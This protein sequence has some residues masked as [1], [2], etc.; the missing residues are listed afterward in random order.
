MPGLV[1]RFKTF[2]DRFPSG[3]WLMMG[4]DTFLTAGNSMVFPFVALYLHNERGLPMSLVGTI[5]LARGLFTGAANVIGGM[6]SD[7][8]GRKRLLLAVLGFN[9]VTYVILAFL[10][11]F[12][13][14][15]WIIALVYIVAQGGIVN[16]T[17]SAIVA[18]LSPAG[19]L[20]EAYAV[21]RIGGNVG[22]ALGPAIGGFLIAIISYGWLLA[23]SAGM[24]VIITVLII[25]FLRE[26]FSG[27]KTGVSLRSTLAV[28][29]DRPFVVFAL[30]S[31][32]L[33]LSIG[34]LGSTLSVFTVERLGFTTAQYGLLLTANGLM[35]VLLQYPVTHLVNKLPKARGLALGSLFY[36]LGWSSFGWVNG[37]GLGILAIMV[38]TLGEVTLVPIS[39]AVVAEAAPEDRRGRYMG[40]FA[41][42]QTLGYSLSPLFGGVLLDAFPAEPR[43]LWGIIGGV[44]AVAAVGFHMWGR[45]SPGMRSETATS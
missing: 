1:A 8:F 5:F 2:V 28:A 22:F 34:H 25:F 16:P 43:L 35:V 33:V 15:V 21:V 45:I 37:F 30:V 26:S 19:R 12:A 38:I 4:L 42:S 9:V 31:V 40:F 23:I 44:G 7:R 3:I 17:I 6:L 27:S 18:D 14:P 13:A 11:G 29:G 32:L 36:V 39:S 20:A 41:L 10:I 24:Y